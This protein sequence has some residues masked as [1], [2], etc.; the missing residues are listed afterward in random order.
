MVIGSDIMLYTWLII[1]L[2][3]GIIEISTTNL[4]CI[5][6]VLSGLL[7]LGV[8]FLTDNVFLQFFVF[9]VFGIIFM[10]LT[11]PFINKMKTKENA[12]TNFDRIIGMKGLVKETIPKDGVGVVKVDGKLWTSYA[13]EKIEEGT[14]VKVLKINSVKLEVEKWKE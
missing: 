14:Y 6:F 11:K 4:V 10:L 8:S 3:L 7:S 1:I 12:R 9:V 2:I 13:N 5:W